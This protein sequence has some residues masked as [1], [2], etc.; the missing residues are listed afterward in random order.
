MKKQILNSGPSVKNYNKILDW[1]VFDEDNKIKINSGKIDIGQHISSTLSLICSKITGVKYEQIEVINLDTDFS[2]N[3]GKTASSLSASHS[4]TAIK[5][6][7]IVL[8]NKFVEY[9][10]EQFEV[11][12]NQIELDNGIAKKKGTND[13]I[14]YWDFAKTDEFKNLIIDEIVEE[15]KYKIFKKIENQSIELKT[16][17]KI[18]SGK[19]KF[20]HDLKFN[21]MIHAR[22]IRPPNYFSEFI[23]IDNK[24]LDKINR[25]NIKIIVKGSFIAILSNDEFLVT[26]YLDIL[27]TAIKWNTKRSLSSQGTFSLIN[28]S[29]KDTLLVKN[30]GEAVFDKVPKIKEF[31]KHSSFITKSSTYK[32]PY[33]MHGSIG[34]S[35]ACAIFKDGKF[36]I[37]THSQGIYDLKIS[38]AKALKTTSDSINLKYRPGSGCYGHNGA[39]DAAFE[40]AFL[41]KEY[42]NQH[43]LLKWTREDEHCWE[44]YGSASINKLTSTLNDKG[45]ILYWSHEVYSDTYMTRPSEKELYN[46][47]SYK[48]IN[49][50]FKK[51]KSK[52][53]TAAHM[54]IHRNLDPLYNFKEKRLVKNLVHGLPLRTSA[55]RTLGAFSNVTA[56]ESFLNELALV[57]NIDP[58][59]FR[60]NHLTDKRGIDVLLDLKSQMSK[61]KQKSNHHRGI[62]FSRYKNLAAYCAVGIELQVT[63]DVDI[64]L[65]KAWIS[66]DAGEIAYK[67]G[68]KYQAEGGLIQASSWCLYEDVKYDAYEIISKDWSKYKIIGFDNIPKIKTNVINRKGFPYLGVGEAVAGPCGGAISNALHA[69]LGQRIKT[70]PFTKENIMKELLN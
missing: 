65:I 50:D 27:K 62:G 16:I 58:F 21:K 35:A 28:E 15:N 41:A 56:L 12:L 19:Y 4:G 25:L 36:T 47:L 43:I 42:P 29:E 31:S 59:D 37:Y 30:G 10:L 44:P 13:T 51:R 67:D 64:K 14:S 7:S 18:V 70:M 32:R 69:A 40:A 45:R 39:D 49:N 33:L 2:P 57:T 34:P 55:L 38:I 6:A 61:D 24:A 20:V 11:E 53:K 3:E 54:G 48:L 1:L 26:K 9:A 60:I 66:I 5:A 68:I 46:F 23:K 52:P 22:I 8:K 17:H 63:D